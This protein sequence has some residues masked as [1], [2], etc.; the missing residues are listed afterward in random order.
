MPPALTL[1]T[2]DP[3]TV[4]SLMI[5][6]NV[7]FNPHIIFDSYSH[8]HFLHFPMVEG[9]WMQFLVASELQLATA[10]FILSDLQ[11]HLSPVTELISLR[12]PPLFCPS[13]QTQPYRL[14]SWVEGTLSSGHHTESSWNHATACEAHEREYLRCLFSSPS[15]MGY[16]CWHFFCLSL[17]QFVKS[18]H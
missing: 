14:L 7:A 11:Y 2:F 18:Q 16:I 17:L 9:C 15:K 1:K 5:I 13:A 6:L 8:S 4:A 12:L 3:I 10:Q